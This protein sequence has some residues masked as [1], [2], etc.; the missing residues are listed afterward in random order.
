MEGMGRD[1]GVQVKGEG[2]LG[3]VG[4]HVSRRAADWLLFACAWKEIREVDVR[5]GRSILGPCTFVPVTRT[6]HLSS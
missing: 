4:V 5:P 1:S 2:L 6:G 3:L